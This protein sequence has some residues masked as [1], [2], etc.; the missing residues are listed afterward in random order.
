MGSKVGNKPWAKCL[1]TREGVKMMKGTEGF[2]DKPKKN[3]S[4][5]TF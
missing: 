4:L 3:L 2:N 5:E 1:E